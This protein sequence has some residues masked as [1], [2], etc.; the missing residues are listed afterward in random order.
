MEYRSLKLY[1]IVVDVTRDIA[2]LIP[3]EKLKMA[4]PVDYRVS[5]ERHDWNTVVYAGYSRPK[6]VNIHRHNSQRPKIRNGNSI[7][8][9]GSSGSWCY[10]QGKTSWCGPCSEI[11]FYEFNPYPQMHST[12]YIAKN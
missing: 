4:K 9:T 1:P 5:L 10:Y 11:R 6:Q 8:R 2:I 3:E 12:L 7:I